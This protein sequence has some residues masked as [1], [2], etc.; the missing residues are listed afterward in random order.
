VGAN[1]DGFKVG[2]RVR[3]SGVPNTYGWIHAITSNSVTIRGAYGD[4]SNPVGRTIAIE[5]ASTG[6]GLIVDLVDNVANKTSYT[7]AAELMDPLTNHYARVRYGD[8]SIKSSWSP[9][10]KFTTG[11]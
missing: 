11:E 6:S 2:N 4:W 8:G 9:W 10:S 1:Q 5:T 7:V 3:L